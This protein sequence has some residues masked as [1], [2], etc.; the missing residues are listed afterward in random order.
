MFSSLIMPVSMYFI[1]ALMSAIYMESFLKS[2]CK[3][4]M[5]IGLWTFI[6]FI[7]QIIIFEVVA[8]IYPIV[9][10]IAIIIN[11]G[12]LFVLQLSMFKKDTAKQLFLIFSFMA[13]KE[14]LK[15][16][17]SVTYYVLGDVGKRIFDKLLSEGTLTTLNQINRYFF[18]EI[19]VSSIVSVL[20]YGVLLGIYLYTI[21]KKYV[22]RVYHFSKPEFVFLIAPAICS[23]C[24]SITIKMMI[25]SLEEG[26]PVFVYEKSPSTLFWIP[27]ACILLLVSV[28]IT[29]M[30]FQNIIQYHEEALQSKVL[31]NQVMQ[32]QKEVSEMQEIYSD[33]RG[34]KHDLRNHL[35]NI[36][37]YI[38]TGAENEELIS[39]IDVMEKILDKL[40]FAY[41]T[42]NPITD[43]IIHQKCQEAKKKRIQFSSDFVYPVKKQID[44]YDVGVILNNALDNAIEACEKVNGE[45]IIK[46]CSYEKGNLFFIE[47]SNNYDSITM[48]IESGFPVTDKKDKN[49]HG[50]GIS[51]IQKAAKKHMGDID[52]EING[53]EK[54]FNLTIMMCMTCE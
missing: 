7:F 9:D 17:S 25:Y 14:I 22:K 24:I 20:T 39:Y 48:D 6:Y 46:L 10:V 44:M 2:K 35:T 26:V 45:R 33:V 3:K 36:A 47:V 32:I 29:V 41:N 15:Y 16:I 49:L 12:L 50:F 40:D 5:T 1:N 28:I 13:G 21:N 11:I 38:T 27:V 53:E 18:I 4:K 8:R 42:G 43:V 51:N 52:I 19:L 23:L 37:A 31:E 30:I 54:I 34:I